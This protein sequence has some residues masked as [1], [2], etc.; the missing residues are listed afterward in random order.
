MADDWSKRYL[1]LDLSLLVPSNV[2]R[3]HSAT[4]DG[5]LADAWLTSSILDPLITCHTGA[6]YH[7]PDHMGSRRPAMAGLR[8]LTADC[9]GLV[10]QPG[11]QM[12]Y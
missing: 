4:D 12:H 6:R 3:A 1:A 2:L 9:M 11:Q 10:L 8:L 5:R 7:R